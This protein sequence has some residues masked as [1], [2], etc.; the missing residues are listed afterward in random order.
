[1]HLLLSDRIWN[2][3]DSGPDSARHS[4]ERDELPVEEDVDV[5]VSRRLASV[6]TVTEPGE[7]ASFEAAVVL[8]ERRLSF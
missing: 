7:E 3:G 6:L 8:V 4:Q 1:L 5:A 2:V